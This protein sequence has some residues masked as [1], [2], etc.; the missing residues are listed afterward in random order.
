MAQL[1]QLQ[2]QFAPAEDRLLLRVSTQDQSEFRFWLTRRYVKLLW[3]A[4]VGALNS[5]QQIARQ[6][7]ELSRQAV[8]SFQHEQAVSQADFGSSFREG[9]TDLPLGQAP[10][11]LAR[12]KSTRTPDGTPVL[13]LL[14]A[15]GQ[16]VE[17]ALQQDLIHSICKLLSD[18]VKTAEWDLELRVAISRVEERVLPSRLMLASL[19][20]MDGSLRRTSIS[21]TICS[22]FC[23]WK[24]TSTR[25]SSKRSL[26]GISKI[27][28]ASCHP[29]V[30]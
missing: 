21:L 8:K 13:S 20:T 24:L 12:I 7:D 25:S 29:G 19:S 5:H 15:E 18:T 3:A 17:V 2:I 28:F 27:F 14:P 30:A 16:G 4:L 11:L 23:P 26:P 10:V 9:A 22:V 1:D 6:S